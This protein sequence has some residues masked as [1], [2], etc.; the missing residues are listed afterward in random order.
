MKKVFA[1]LLA[2]TLCLTAVAAVAETADIPT[3]A[4]EAAYEGTPVA[5]GDTGLTIS[6]PSDWA[7]A[8]APEGYYFVYTNPENTMSISIQ[9]ALGIDACWEAASAMVE[10]ETA[11]DLQEMFVNETYYL[12]YSTADDLF[13]FAYAP[14]TDDSCIAICF[15]LVSKDVDGSIALQILSTL[16]AAE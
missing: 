9:P 3:V 6:I 13:N 7:L 8:Q 2:L 5:I 4:V 15:G 14:V 1:L 12:V 16:A 11:K 10:A